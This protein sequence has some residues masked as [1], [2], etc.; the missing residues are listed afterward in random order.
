M[1]N[2][3][4]TL[5]RYV[6]AL[7]I[8]CNHLCVCT[9]REIF[10]CN[11]IIFVFGFFAMSGF[12]NFNSY[13]RTPSPKAFAK[14][15]FRR[16]YPAY[17]LAVVFC[18]LVGACFTSLPLKDFLLHKEAWRYLFFN[19]IFLN[20]QQP[21]L[22]GL[23]E[24]NAMAAVNSSLWTMK[25][26]VLFY[27]SVPVVHWL[28][29]R[30]GHN[31]TLISII[32]ASLA[33]NYLTEWAYLATG[34]PFYSTLNHQII[35]NLAVFYTPVLMLYH[36]EWVRRHGQMLMWCALAL[37]VPFFFRYEFHYLLPIVLPV[38]VVTFAYECRWLLFTA[39]W[40]D[41]SY[42]F[43]LFRFPVLQVLA[44]LGLGMPLTLTA[45]LAL[46]LICLLAVPAH[47]LSKAI[48][49]RI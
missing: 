27:L 5:L 34:N 20:Y 42:E 1:R 24:G 29:E 10:L 44:S 43:Y 28:T 9:G 18:F 45:L 39:D 46:L 14:K 11:G 30:F 48:A 49:D 15:R 13:R 33:Y 12:L 38:L 4:F 41:F 25:V 16:I 8:F 22:P 26:E 3:C 40:K 37:L 21:T 31:K 19:L 2:N 47:Y 6:F 35:G 7:C 23:F 17:A 32:I 36:M